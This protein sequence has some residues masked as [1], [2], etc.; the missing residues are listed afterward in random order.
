MFGPVRFKTPR[1][2]TVFVPS[3]DLAADKLLLDSAREE[4]PVLVATQTAPDPRLGARPGAWTLLVPQQ[5]AIFQTALLNAKRVVTYSK[6][7]RA[8]AESLRA[9]DPEADVSS[10]QPFA[11]CCVADSQYLPFFFALVENL[12]AVHAGPLEIHLLAVDSGVEPAV[13]AQ[14][15]DRNI[16]IYPIREV[17]TDAEW[18]RISQRPISLRALSCKP[19]I[20]LKARQNSDAEALFLLDL[21]IYFLRSPAHLNQ[22]FGTGNTLFFPQWSD[23]FTWARLH[24]IFNSGMVGAKKGAE[25]FLSWWSRACW[26]SCELEVE[27]GRFGDQAFIDQALLYFDGIQIY[28]GLDEDI[29]PWN[30]RTLEVAKSENGLHVRGGR[31]VGSF[32]AAG[33]DDDGIFEWKYT[34]DQLVALF[35]VIDN[36]DESRALFR[37]VLEQQRR[38]WP[39]LDQALRLRGLVESRLK[40]PVAALTPSWTES[41]TRAG[42]TRFFSACSALHRVYGKW[43]G[44][45]AAPAMAP[46][47]ND[48]WIQLQRTALFTPE[49]L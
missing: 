34:W 9:A 48:F 19:R 2:L 10:A 27:Q 12:T 7:V 23:R 20:F 49:H 47:E 26:I 15:P 28:R 42:A 18:Q 14:Y 17:W 41:V 36:P 35:S 8:L 24:G 13:R 45:S 30:R 22:A 4:G 32:H 40:W 43:R 39:G 38:H 16:R 37:N 3:G 25:P 21:D 11:F 29:A 5:P 1:E 31:S 44:H 6:S 46:T 33:P